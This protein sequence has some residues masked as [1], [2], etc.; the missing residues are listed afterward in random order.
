[1]ACESLCGIEPGGGT[2]VIADVGCCDDEFDWRR[3]WNVG[4]SNGFKV[5]A[6]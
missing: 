5:D 1:M 2:D 3:D 4:M 6:G